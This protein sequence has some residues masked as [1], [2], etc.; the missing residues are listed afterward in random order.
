M[1]CI[2][3]MYDTLCRHFL[4]PYGNTWVKTPNFA[5]LAD[6]AVTFDNN[7]VCSLPCM[8][9]RRDLHNARAN[10]LQRDWGAL[11]PYDDSMPEILRQNGIYSCLVSDHYHY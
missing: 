3:V 11:E 1:R 10:F 8:P 5:R 7:Y 2:M 6:R 9:A 4:S